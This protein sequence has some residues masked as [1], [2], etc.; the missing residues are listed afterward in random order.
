VSSSARAWRSG[1]SRTATEPAH[2]VDRSVSG[3]P[4]PRRIVGIVAT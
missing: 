2:V 3:K 4:V 1:C